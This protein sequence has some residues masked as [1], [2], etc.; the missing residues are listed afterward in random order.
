MKKYLII[1]LLLIAIPSWG[2]D[3]KISALSTVNPAAADLF[4]GLQGG[5]N[6]NFAWGA[7][8]VSIKGLTFADASILQLTGAGTAAVLTSGGNYYTLMSTSDN[9]ALNFFSPS[10]VR[11]AL[12]LVVG[13]NVQAY[14]ADHASIAAGIT[15]LVKGAGNGA[16]YSA[17]SAGTDY[18]APAGSGAALTGITGSQIA[19]PTVQAVSCSDSGDGNHGALTITP[20]AGLDT[21][22]INLTV[23][24]AHGCTITMAETSA[25]AGT[26]V[27]IT[28]ISAYH[29]DFADQAGILEMM[30]SLD[31]SQNE[32]LELVYTNSQ[33]YEKSRSVASYRNLTFGGFTASKVVCTDGS[34]NQVV[35][36]NLTDLA[37]SSYAPLASP[38]FTGVVDIPAGATTDAEGE[39][40]ID[41]TTDQLRYYGSA[42]KVIP[43]L[44]Y[45]SFVI[46]APVDT[47]DIL[48]MK[49]PYGMTITGI[50]CIVQGTTSVH[51]QIQECDSAGANC[52]DT[53]DTDDITCDA[54][55]AADDGT[56][57]NAVIDKDD[58]LMWKTTSLVDT[59]TFLTVT[60]TYTVV[61]D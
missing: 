7:N 42:Q 34:G 15:G 30:G 29:A 61:A 50:S 8:L 49:A 22:Y 10:D 51:G 23:L 31:L 25:V 52:A 45:A 27:H 13:T 3:T 4:T 32:T 2:A 39:I 57:S 24:D 11:T 36:T 43:S 41:T 1:L 55:G 5:A 53:D 20:T 60:F 35:C 54:D 38:V 56:L 9:S 48:I 26:K 21:V 6:V 14:D 18:L 59:P 19:P 44:Q 40:T 28:N 16:G 58:W 33:W 17:A 37:F 47:D 46:P 12:G